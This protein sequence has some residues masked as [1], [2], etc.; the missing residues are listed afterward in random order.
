[1]ARGTLPRTEAPRESARLHP[2]VFISRRLAGRDGQRVVRGLRGQPARAGGAECGA[3]P[4]PACAL[5]L[6]A[7]V[8]RAARDSVDPDPAVPP[9]VPDLAVEEAGRHAPSSQLRGTV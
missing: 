5:A 2:G 7:D 3:D 4:E 8:R 9:G 6:H 1:M